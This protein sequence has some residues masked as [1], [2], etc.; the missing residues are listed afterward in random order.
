M[1]GHVRVPVALAKR[2]LEHSGH[3]ALLAAIVDEVARKE[4]MA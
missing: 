1:V 2:A 3:R 4:K